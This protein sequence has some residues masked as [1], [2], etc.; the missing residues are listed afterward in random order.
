MTFFAGDRAPSTT[1]W[2]HQVV[3]CFGSLCSGKYRK[4]GGTNERVLRWL[5]YLTAFDYTRPSTERAA[6]T[7]TTNSSHGRH[8]QR[9]STTAMFLAASSLSTMAPYTSSGLAAYTPFT[10][11]P[12]IGLGELILRPNG[13]VLG[14]L[15]LSSSHFGDL[16][17]H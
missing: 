6:P 5:E 15:P 11:I 10:L 13:V 7:V 16:H 2:G 9:P 12:G 8:S 3:H 1:P 14:V 4:I 17:A